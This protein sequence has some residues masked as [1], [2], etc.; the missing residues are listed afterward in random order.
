VSQGSVYVWTSSWRRAP[1]AAPSEPRSLSAVFRLPLDGVA[2]SAL[3]TAGVPID[4]MSFLEGSGHLNV[5]LREAGGGEGMWGSEATAGAMA[6]LRVP[7]SLFG[8]GRD[9]ARREHYRRQPSVSGWAVQNRF[10]GDWL[11]WGG[12]A[13]A[14]DRTPSAWA[15]RYATDA[16]PLALAAPHAI[17]RIEALGGDALLV[18]SRGGDLHFSAVRL[19]R[20]DARLGGQ[21]VELGVAQGET[22]THGFFYRPQGDDYG[23][24]G[25]PVLGVAGRRRGVYAGAQGS[26]AVLFV[27]NRALRF[28]GLGSL[29]ASEAGVRDD[30]CKASCVDWY[31]NA[32]PIFLGDRVL[33]L[34]GYEIVEG[35]VES[36]GWRF[37]GDASGPGGEQVVERR[38]VSFA[39]NAAWREGRYWPFG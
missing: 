15:V 1:G 38:R 21:H 34:M 11:L 19:A 39:P 27:R 22:R 25:L 36:V 12:A 2:P 10:V 3:K 5:L 13:G 18:G 20:G 24:L 8:D 7:L 37:E 30:G 4:Q 32:R 23:V 35:R 9:S 31:G 33:A 17:E 26:A 28:T 6:L 14:G 16:P 29:R